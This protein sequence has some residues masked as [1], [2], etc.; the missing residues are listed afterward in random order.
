MLV[1]TLLKLRKNANYVE[2][3]YISG[4]KM[5]DLGK[6]TKIIKTLK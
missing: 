5:R 6:M 3:G 2:T 1:I 4:G